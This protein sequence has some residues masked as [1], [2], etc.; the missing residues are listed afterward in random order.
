MLSAS[1]RAI[2]SL[3][4]AI[5][6]LS[7][8]ACRSA[9]VDEPPRAA[10]VEQIAPAPV[11]SVTGELAIVDA[12]PAAASAEPPAMKRR[13]PGNAAPAPPTLLEIGAPCT[14]AAAPLA[15]HP[16]PFDPCGTKGRVSV[17][18]N[19]FSTSLGRIA[20]CTMGAIGKD[21]KAARPT[22][23]KRPGARA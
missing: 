12:P 6:A 2:A 17:R 3:A 1:T 20:P 7:P 4:I 10:T 5:A 13:H 16:A 21:A 8:L 9:A 14:A 23:S 11:T 18:W 15:G 19:A 22:F